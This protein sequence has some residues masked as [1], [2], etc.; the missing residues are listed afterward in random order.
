M[1]SE[2]SITNLLPFEHH[3]KTVRWLTVFR[4]LWRMTYGSGWRKGVVNHCLEFG[5]RTELWDPPL[6]TLTLSSI[7][8]LR[9][10]R[11]LTA[12]WNALWFKSD[13]LRSDECTLLHSIEAD[14][15]PQLWTLTFV[16]L[17]DFWLKKIFFKIRIHGY[18]AL[19]LSRQTWLPP[20]FFISRGIFV[21]FW[22]VEIKLLG[23]LAVRNPLLHWVSALCSFLNSFTFCG[24]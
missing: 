24:K 9:C 17:K 13:T 21:T 2:L 23:W 8:P 6:S 7:R 10:S 15:S 12:L 4:D 20:L 19:S 11:I 5:F 1:W 3:R 16:Y 14:I 22:L 18:F